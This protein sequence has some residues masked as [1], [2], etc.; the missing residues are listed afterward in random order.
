MDDKKKVELEEDTIEKDIIRDD[1][2]DRRFDL[3]FSKYDGVPMSIDE[4]IEISKKMR[5]FK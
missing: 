5:R 3:E 4:F 2:W 1:D